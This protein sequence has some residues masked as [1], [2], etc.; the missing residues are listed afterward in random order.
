[1]LRTGAQF[2]TSAALS[3]VFQSLSLEGTL[4]AVHPFL[5]THGVLYIPLNERVLILLALRRTLSFF[6]L[7]KC[8]KLLNNYFLYSFPFLLLTVPTK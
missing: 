4:N 2:L 3:N 7:R 5:L 1:M 8:Q 6:L